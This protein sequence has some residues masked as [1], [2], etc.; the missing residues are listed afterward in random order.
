M[1]KKSHVSVCSIGLC[2][3]NLMY[4]RFFFDQIQ[5]SFFLF[6]IVP[7]L[8]KRKNNPFLKAIIAMADKENE[9][10]S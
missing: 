6:H 7:F 1:K 10:K 9:S 4:F 8:P 2:L 3:D 5:K